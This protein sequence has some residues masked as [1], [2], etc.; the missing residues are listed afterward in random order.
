MGS[1]ECDGAP[2]SHRTDPEACVTERDPS[3]TDVWKTQPTKYERTRN[4]TTTRIPQTHG[5]NPKGCPHA[6]E[7]HC[8]CPHVERSI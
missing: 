6:R 8:A 3:K 5:A 2:E 1:V 7:G 4:E